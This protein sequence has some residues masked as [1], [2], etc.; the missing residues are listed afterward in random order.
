MDL[1]W[2]GGARYLGQS[3]KTIFG[4][5]SQI[6]MI[7]L[8]DHNFRFIPD[9]KQLASHTDPDPAVHMNKN[10]KLIIIIPR[11][12]FRS[13]LYSLRWGIQKMPATAQMGSDVSSQVLWRVKLV[14]WLTGCPQAHSTWRHARWS[15]ILKLALLWLSPTPT[16]TWCV[17]PIFCLYGLYRTLCM[18]V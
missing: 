3:A 4:E 6:N 9:I 8:C 17:Q 11:S 10:Q 14:Q 15:Q 12:I 16:S 7:C 18:C 13:S 5:P 1:A 2:V